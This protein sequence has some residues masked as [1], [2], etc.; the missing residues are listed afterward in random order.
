MPRISI[1]IIFLLLALGAKAQVPTGEI[2]GPYKWISKIYPGTERN[3]WLYIPAQYDSRKAACSMIVQDGLGRANGWRL[4]AHL[5][6]L[7]H[8]GEIPVIIGIYIDHGRVISA[9][10]SHYPRFNRSFEYDGLGDRYARFL[11]E[12]IIPEVKKSYNLSDDPN[13]RSIAGASS[14]AICAFNA[15]WERPDAFRRVLSTIGT[16]VGLRGADETATLVRKTEPKPLRIFL[17]DGYHDLNIYAGDW[18]IA[19]QNLLSALTWAGYEVNHAWG[20]GGHNNTHTL[21]VIADALR[22]LWKDYPAPVTSPIDRYRGMSLTKN[23]GEWS[24]LPVSKDGLNQIAAAPDGTVYFTGTDGTSIYTV[25]F[26]P[27]TIFKRIVQGHINDLTFDASGHPIYSDAGA[28]AIYI[29]QNNKA[30][31][32]IRSAKPGQVLSTSKGLYFMNGLQLGYYHYETKKTILHPLKSGVSGMA[33]TSEKSYLNLIYPDEVFGYS[34]KIN[35]DG[36]LSHGQEYIHYHIPYGE[37]TASPHGLATDTANLLYTGTNMGVQVSDQ[38]GRVNLILPA[39]NGPVTDLCFGGKE[40]NRL[41]IV[42]GGNAYF[43]ILNTKGNHPTAPP[44]KPP[45]PGM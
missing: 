7:I 15:A 45:R 39:P 17:E 6:T 35:P 37:K 42:S 14:G 13:D 34:Y 3:Y 41:F 25:S 33:I 16:Y 23:L 40:F 43:R 18:Y 32:L 1:G 24:E 38:L 22:W 20:E 28:G 10:T 11:M 8:R 21:T 12:E 9:D 44:A 19:N 26:D 31:T 36:S 2:K 29:E 27:A 30:S 5:D 4:S